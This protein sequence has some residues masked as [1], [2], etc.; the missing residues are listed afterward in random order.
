MNIS[1]ESLR[2]PRLSVNKSMPKKIFIV[3]PKVSK[4]KKNNCK[5]FHGRGGVKKYNVYNVY[6][7]SLTTVMNLTNLMTL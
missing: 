7:D 4:T 2:G 6:K 1:H 3:D 5:E